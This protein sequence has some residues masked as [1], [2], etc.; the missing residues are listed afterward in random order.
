MRGSGTVAVV[1]GSIA[2]CAFASA[3]A[4]A[5]AGEVVV[6]ER[7]GGRLADRGS[8]CVSTTTGP[9]NSPR[10]GRCPPGSPR[11]RW[12]GVAGWSGIRRRDRAG[13]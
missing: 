5:G 2:G 13:G 7:T 4:R 1:G 8:G 6:L 11:T 12:H 10:P 3:A 9:P